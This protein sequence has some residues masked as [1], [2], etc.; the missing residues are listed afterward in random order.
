MAG[1]DALAQYHN[2]HLSF[3]G[4]WLFGLQRAI[5]AHA[6]EGY[7]CECTPVHSLGA[8]RHRVVPQETG[9]V[10]RKVIAGPF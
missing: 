2:E 1:E 7:T 6:D 9:L 8:S 4:V 5:V 10:K 3:L